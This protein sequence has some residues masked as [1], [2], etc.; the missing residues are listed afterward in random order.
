MAKTDKAVR[1]TFEIETTGESSLHK[2]QQAAQ[3][4]GDTFDKEFGGNL[5]KV[6]NQAEMS[7]K[8]IDRAFRSLGTRSTASYRQQ[9][10]ALVGS[11]NELRRSGK[12]S[13]QEQQRAYAALQRSV[14]RVRTEM[15]EA[16]T[17]GASSMRRISG[18]ARG[19]SQVLRTIGGTA[20]LYKL[21]QGVRSAVMGFADFDDSIRAAGAV[22]GV[23]GD[24]FK[25]LSDE[26]KRLG[27]ETRFSGSEAAAGFLNLGR[28][29]QTLEQAIGT[30]P[31]VLQLTAA[32]GLDLGEA[33]DITTNILDAYNL[34]VQDLA[35]AN[36]VLVATFTS[37]NSVLPEIGDAMKY[38]A[39]IAAG[40]GAQFEETAAAVGLL[41]SSGTKADMAGTALRNMLDRLYNPTDTVAGVIQKLEKR[42]GGVAFQV[43]NAQGNFVGFANILEQLER[44][45]LTAGEALEMF[46]QRAGPAVVSLMNKGS[47]ALRRF[48]KELENS[49]GT[50]K[51]I[52]D[53]MENGIGGALRELRSGVE[54]FSNTIGDDLEPIVR[55]MA[56]SLRDLTRWFA[57]MA[58]GY[59]YAAEAVVG[60]AAGY[61][62]LKTAMVGLRLVSAVSS[63]AGISSSAGLATTAVG[64]LTGA[65]TA[66]NAVIVGPAGL[67]VAVG[68]AL[69]ILAK[70]VEAHIETKRVIEESYQAQ[71]L[72]YEQ[73]GK[74]YMQLGRN[75]E[76]INKKYGT[77]LQMNKQ[78]LI[79]MSEQDKA[80]LRQAGALGK[81]S[82]AIDET[83]GRTPTITPRVDSEQAEKDLKEL[84]KTEHK[85]L[86]IDVVGPNRELPSG[87][88]NFL[89]LED[90]A[91]PE[92]FASGGYVRRR[93][94][95]P[96]FG[97]GDRI[98]ALLE[99][100]EY[101]LDKFTTRALGVEALKR[102]QASAR[103]SFSM[104]KVP[105]SPIQHFSSGGLVKTPAA[106]P[107]LGRMELSVGNATV[108]AYMDKDAVNAV[109]RELALQKRRRSSS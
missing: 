3:K 46:G 92:G 99:A 33:A 69:S 64:G 11:Y 105:A 63:L 14:A 31:N 101:I 19:L 10:T 21:Q 94:F 32:G 56:N 7:A 82:K 62:A 43:E 84:A 97:G 81:L 25:R 59:R 15:K 17:A 86:I 80:I 41:H 55:T 88:Y 34:T 5:K 93:G 75:L 107:Y 54:G 37:T 6:A 79:V 96:G 45:G 108:N 83:S 98:P 57:G 76:A 71:K 39:P 70:L 58:P 90:G 53:D 91:M 35:H 73:A 38:V 102:I 103:R 51:R 30:L 24:D 65:I 18:E 23:T 26:A 42:M 95:L 13:A 16:G 89:K 29:G 68:A 47:D 44:G 8:D 100:G 27:I 1:I 72:G 22:M 77:H 48:T 106:M 87:S 4:T 52:A 49:G 66:M 36:D 20:V 67:V 85:K 78:G 104:P 2:L 40:V 12:L 28:A 109:S 61:V 50:A 9:L 74:N 60:L